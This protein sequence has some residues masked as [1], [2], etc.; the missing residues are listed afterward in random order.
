MWSIQGTPHSLYENPPEFMEALLAVTEEHNIKTCP[1]DSAEIKLV[2][3]KFK[4]VKAAN[5]IPPK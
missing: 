5:D 4:N 1:P 2:L 3:S